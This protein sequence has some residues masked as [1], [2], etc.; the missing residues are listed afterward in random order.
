MFFADMPLIAG[1]LSQDELSGLLKALF[2]QSTYLVKL[3]ISEDTNIEKINDYW[4]RGG[5]AKDVLPI[6][7]SLQHLEGPQTIDVVHFLPPLP[8]RRLYTFPRPWAP[9]PQGGGF[10][11]CHWT[12]FNFFNP[13][14]DDRFAQP[15][16]VAKTLDN[17]YEEVVGEPVLGDIVTF[18]RHDGTI[19]HTANYIAD[20]L[21]YSKNGSK[22]TWP[23]FFVK[24]ESMI[25]F[26]PKTQPVIIKYFRAKKLNSL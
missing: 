22:S 18:G 8:R 15:D 16:F 10:R 21:L 23:W 2:R 17:D 20:G 13:D 14:P 25:D 19:F 6:L 4:G 24:L 7:E 1:S 9:P 26:Y 5:R 3:K 12:S 11:D